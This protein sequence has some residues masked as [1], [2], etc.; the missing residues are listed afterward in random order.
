M[1]CVCVIV[2]FCNRIDKDGEGS[3]NLISSRCKY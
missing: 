2:D 1:F 3:I